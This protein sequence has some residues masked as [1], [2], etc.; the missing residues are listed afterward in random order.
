MRRAYRHQEVVLQRLALEPRYQKIK[1]SALTT[2]SLYIQGV[3]PSESDLQALKD[4]VA[5]TRSPVHVDYRVVVVP[6]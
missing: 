3:L 6:K 2:G 1:V 5:T 4:I